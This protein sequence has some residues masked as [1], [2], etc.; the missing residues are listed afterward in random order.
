[1]Y[2]TSSVKE[3]MNATIER[4]KDEMKKVHA[5]VNALQPH[6]KVIEASHGDVEVEDILSDM[7][8][9][10]VKAKEE[11]E[12]SKKMLQD[13]NEIKEKMQ[14]EQTKLDKQKN[15]ILSKAKIEARDLLLD[16]ETQANDIIKELTAIKS[17]N[18]K[19]SRKES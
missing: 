11:R 13:A 14:L 6:V 4:F 15:E 9:E 12:L 16:A 18:S 1:M 8:H 19:N 3:K 17:V 7:E 5:V 10:R 2:D